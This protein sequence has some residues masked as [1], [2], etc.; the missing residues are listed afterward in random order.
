[1]ICHDVR[2]ENWLKTRPA[3]VHV[4]ITKAWERAPPRKPRLGRHGKGQGVHNSDPGRTDTVCAREEM[5][6]IRHL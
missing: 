3:L 2:V 1:M 5:T 4:G 6:L